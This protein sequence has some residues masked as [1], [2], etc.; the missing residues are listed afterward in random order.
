MKLKR[1]LGQHL[2]RDQHFISRILSAL[3]SSPQRVIE[4]GPG[5][6]A[7]TL[8]LH[9]HNRQVLGIEADGR[10]VAY[11]R[12][13]GIELIEGD[14]A[15]PQWISSIA[16]GEWGVVGNLPYYTATKILRNLVSHWQRFP[17]LVLMFQKE[18]A[19]RIFFVGTRQGGI[20]GVWCQAVY[21]VERILDI[22]PQAFTPPPRVFSTLLR[23][24]R[25]DS[26]HLLPEE[27]EPYWK[28]LCQAFSRRRGLL[29]HS[30]ARRGDGSTTTW[31]Q[32]FSRLGFPKNLR[33][34]E[35]SP[36]QFL[37]LWRNHPYEKK[38]L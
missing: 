34:E 13:K 20:L 11:L 36:Q 35:L 27:A 6:G 31:L 5:T 12:K 33:A 15:S 7:L 37:E 19:N 29:I 2:L 38:E 24:E 16:S 10:M 21:R 25:L 18:V 22:P 32:V 3:P 30:L 8:P 26:P 28:F 14:A 23:F 17:W 1:S 9:E 4:I